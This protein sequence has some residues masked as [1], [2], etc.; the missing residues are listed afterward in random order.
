VPGRRLGDALRAVRSG[1][2]WGWAAAVVGACKA[3]VG[4]GASGDGLAADGAGAGDLGG[5]GFVA[6]RRPATSSLGAG[7]SI[8]SATSRAASAKRLSKEGNMCSQS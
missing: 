3:G 4:G 2:R 6:V 5:S 8:A 7:A 1:R